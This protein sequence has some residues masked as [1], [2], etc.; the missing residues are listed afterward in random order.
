VETQ[1]PTSTLQL[2]NK[3]KQAKLST[4][5]RTQN[6]INLSNSSLKKNHSNHRVTQNSKISVCVRDGLKIGHKRLGNVEIPISDLKTFK[7]KG[8]I[9]FLIHFRSLV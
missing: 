6:S 8:K 4:T 9:T 2:V 5:K 1:T 3:K 7:T